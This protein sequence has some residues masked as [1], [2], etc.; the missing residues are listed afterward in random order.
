[1]SVQ[2]C[3]KTAVN[4]FYCV[5]RFVHPL[6]LMTQKNFTYETFNKYFIKPQ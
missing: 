6:G 5:L 2:K 1:M 4:R 3:G